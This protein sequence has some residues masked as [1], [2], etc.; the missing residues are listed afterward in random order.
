MAKGL[1]PKRV[2]L[3]TK[4]LD[5]FQ[6][7]LR[8]DFSDL[9]QGLGEALGLYGRYGY[10]LAQAISDAREAEA[11]M[12]SIEGEL[13][14]I[15]KNDPLESGK[16]PSDTYIRMELVQDEDWKEAQS[17]LLKARRLEQDLR[18]LV[19]GLEYK[20]EALRTLL[21]N[22]RMDKSLHLKS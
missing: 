14:L 12:T 13:Y 19:R 6:D 3:P 16:I 22:E 10:M 15:S 21:A 8:I 7:V 17:K 11:S 1:K 5:G 2:S 18:V 4:D 20:L 9:E